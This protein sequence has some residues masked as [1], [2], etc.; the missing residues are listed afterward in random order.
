[1]AYPSIGRGLFEAASEAAAANEA[2]ARGA[3]K[4]RQKRNGARRQP[5]HV[6][7]DSAHLLPAPGKA[8]SERQ[9][10]DSVDQA[11]WRDRV[12][13][14]LKKLRADFFAHDATVDHELRRLALEPQPTVAA[15]NGPEAPL[16]A[17][18]DDRLR[19]LEERLSTAFEVQPS[20]PPGTSELSAETF[21]RIAS[22]EQ[23]VETLADKHAEL[24]AGLEAVSS[25]LVAER[26]RNMTLVMAVVAIGL[27]NLAVW[28]FSRAPGG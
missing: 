7:E 28:L 15:A 4:R 8:A 26:L 10:R 18:M 12:E 21:E 24:T 5:H 13:A 17:E 19:R 11:L 9:A 1:M 6:I 16:R 20:A 2:L 27:A 14:D 25:S 22:L 3:A 23:E